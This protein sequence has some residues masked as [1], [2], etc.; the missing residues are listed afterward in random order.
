MSYAADPCGLPGDFTETTGGLSA[1]ASLEFVRKSLMPYLTSHTLGST[2]RMRSSA[3][4][5]T[6]KELSSTK[7]PRQDRKAPTHPAAPA[8]RPR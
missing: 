8:T 2:M 5:T 6:T 4:E 1:D 7:R 3:T